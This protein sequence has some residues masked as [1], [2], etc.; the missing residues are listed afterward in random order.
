MTGERVET[1]TVTFEGGVVDLY[2][3]RPPLEA[4]LVVSTRP[5]DWA[6]RARAI[7]WPDG[8]DVLT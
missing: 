5:Q 4:P 3:T 7:L 6:P 2:V 8:V 1:V